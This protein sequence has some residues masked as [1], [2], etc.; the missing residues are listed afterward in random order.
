M[1]YYIKRVNIEQKRVNIEQKRVNIEQ[2]RVNIEQKRVNIEQ[3]RKQSWK[4]I[5]KLYIFLTSTHTKKNQQ[6]SAC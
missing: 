4:I 3:K 5:E 2:K 1:K 6:K